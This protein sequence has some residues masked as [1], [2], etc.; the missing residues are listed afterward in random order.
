MTPTREEILEWRRRHMGE[1]YAAFTAKTEETQPKESRMSDE[2]PQEPEVPQSTRALA[3]ALMQTPTA[4]PT[5]EPDSEQEPVVPDALAAA[6]A[7]R[8]RRKDNKGRAH[9]GLLPNQEEE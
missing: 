8:L 1:L 3:A 6:V 4:G 5:P 2:P 7:A 9:L